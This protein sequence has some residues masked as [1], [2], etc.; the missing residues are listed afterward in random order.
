ML[1]Y[2]D[3]ITV[4]IFLL[5]RTIC[6]TERILARYFAKEKN[7]EERQKKI[8]SLMD[9]KTHTTAFESFKIGKDKKKERHCDTYNCIL[10]VRPLFTIYSFPDLSRG[11][12]R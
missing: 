3:S 9:I 5:L 1:P 4:A 7:D 8:F 6:L 11:G 10:T 2:D 12:R